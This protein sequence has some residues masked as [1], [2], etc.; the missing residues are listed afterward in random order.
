MKKIKLV[1]VIGLL[2]CSLVLLTFLNKLNTTGSNSKDSQNLSMFH[3]I[4]A[5]QTNL[6]ANIK[7][8]ENYC[9]RIPSCR[10]APPHL[11]FASYD[12]SQGFFYHLDYDT[13]E[14]LGLV[15]NDI[16][17]TFR[18]EDLPNIYDV[19]DIYYRQK[20]VFKRNNINVVGL[21]IDFD[22][23]S[24]KLEIY[25]RW[26]SQLSKL[27][28]EDTL[29]VTGLMS[30]IEDNKEETEKLMIS[31]SKINFQLY[32]KNT[33]LRPTDR[34]IQF[35]QSNSNANVA[36][37]CVKDAFIDSLRKSTSKIKFLSVGFFLDNRCSFDPELK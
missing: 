8:L 37:F 16:V 10:M 30:W 5:G 11:H 13:L 27:L 24:A 36:L 31:V 14:N 22:S 29:E 34:F 6:P 33:N 28:D 20:T 32:Q 17:L 4:W 26:L 23:P 25:S 21:E 9:E 1:G 7:Y 2:L 18:L 3:W 19:G 35:V 15:G 12:L